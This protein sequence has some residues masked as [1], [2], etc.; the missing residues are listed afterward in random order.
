MVLNNGK[1]NKWESVKVQSH[2]MG[3]YDLVRTCLHP[4]AQMKEGHFLQSYSVEFFPF[5]TSYALLKNVYHLVLIYRDDL[6]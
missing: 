3:I 2:F 5:S 6:I 1:N 4:R